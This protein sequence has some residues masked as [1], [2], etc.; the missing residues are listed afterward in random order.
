MCILADAA[1]AVEVRGTDAFF[2]WRADA[3]A[4]GLAV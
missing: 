4:D 3:M 1:T 2:H